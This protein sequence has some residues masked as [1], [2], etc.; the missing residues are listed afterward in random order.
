MF[1]GAPIIFR[2]FIPIFLT[3]FLCFSGRNKIGGYWTFKQATTGVFVMF[4][5]AFLVQFIGK[6]LI[7]D[8]LIAPDNIQKTQN[9][10]IGFK[11]M[12]LK[13]KGI[14]NQAIE[15]DNAEMRKDFVS[16]GSNTIGEIIRGIIFSILFIFI[17]ALIFGSLFKKDPPAYPTNN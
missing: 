15:K 10:A 16:Q 4:L 8:K 3:A 7:F 6:D 2:I 12:I 13:Q 5:I 14:S 1:V 11:T 9:A 17:L